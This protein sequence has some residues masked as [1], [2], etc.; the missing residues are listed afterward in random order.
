MISEMLLVW[1]DTHARSLP[2]RGIHDPYRTWVSEA[3][4]QQTRVDTVIPYYHRFLQAFP[5]LPALAAASEDEVLKLWEGLGYYSRARNLLHGARQVMQ[6]FGGELPPDPAGLLRI[7]GIGPYTARAIASIAFDI[8]V[9]AVDGNVIRVVSRLFDIREDPSHGAAREK[10]ERIAAELVPA[11]RPGDYNQ[12]VMDLGATVCVPGTPDCDRCPLCS[13]CAAFRIGNA[14][15]LP[16]IPSVRPPRELDYDV[17]I[18]CCGAH[19][20]L[21]KRTEKLLQGLW[22]FPM[23]DGKHT[24]AELLQL[25]QKKLRLDPVRV[26][27]A[28][29]ARHVFTHQVWKMNLY[30][31]EVEKKPYSRSR[32]WEKPSGTAS[33][34]ELPGI[35]EG[36]MWIKPEKLETL[37]IPAAMKAAVQTVLQRERL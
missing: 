14:A 5:T 12:A 4:L 13:V 28:G 1:Y 26:G 22:C 37:A 16:A 15:V 30:I 32:E 21:R 33:D 20:L 19:V 11:E 10:I 24:E 6:E 25:I 29:Q 23:M 34:G 18:I 9:P 27:A 2:W 3:M 36:Y 8:P 7:R 35:P 31:T 17:L